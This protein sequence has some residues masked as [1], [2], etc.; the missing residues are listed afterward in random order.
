VDPRSNTLYPWDYDYKDVMNIVG[1]WLD[2]VMINCIT[3][4][5]QAP[6]RGV[7]CL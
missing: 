2:L 3:L 6:L 4:H 1:G 5:H 7:F